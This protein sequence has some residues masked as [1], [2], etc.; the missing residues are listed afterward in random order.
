MTD[1]SLDKSLGG[2]LKRVRNSWGWF[3][4]AGIALVLFGVYALG[5]LFAATIASI[6]VVGVMMVAGGIAHIVLSFRA[7]TWRH[8]L[9]WLLGGVLYLVAGGFVLADPILAS[10]A[11]TLVFAISVMAAGLVRI[12]FGFAARPQSGW[13]WLIAAGVITFATGVV[14]LSGWPI[15]SLWVIGTVLAVDLLFQG[16]GHIAFGLGLRRS[17]LQAT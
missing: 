15:S 10:T 11:L 8:F 7:R 4:A 1:V 13:G 14:I 12:W 16:W 17:S 2:V 9:I 6:F 5:N 3:V